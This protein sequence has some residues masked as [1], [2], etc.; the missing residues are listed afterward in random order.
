MDDIAKALGVNKS[1]VSRAINNH[2]LISTEMREKIEKMCRKMN[3]IPNSI[4]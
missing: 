2:S 1:T 4:S 3:Y